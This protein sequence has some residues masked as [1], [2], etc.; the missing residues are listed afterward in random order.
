VFIMRIF[1]LYL[2]RSF[3]MPRTKNFRKVHAPPG[4]QGYRPFGT[5][6]Q[7][8]EEVELLFEEYEAIKLADYDLLNHQEASKLMEVSRATFARIYESARRKIAHALVESR[9]I[10]AVCGHAK[11]EKPWQK[12]N[13]CHNRFTLPVKPWPGVCPR[14]KSTEFQILTKS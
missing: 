4:F 7:N 10:H 14:C 11:L 12:C 6:V 3:A 2:H 5:S 8:R 1:S 9:S 13:E